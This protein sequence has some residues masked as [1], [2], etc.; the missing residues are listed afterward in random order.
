VYGVLFARLFYILNPPPSVVVFYDTTWYFSHPFDLQA[1]PLAIW[2]GG[3]SFAGAVVGVTVAVLF[4]LHRNKVDFWNWADRVI[5][6]L[7]VGAALVPWG[8]I[9][10][11]H[12]YGLPTTLPWGML[13]EHPAAPFESYTL[14]HPVP[15]Y[16][17]LLAFA[18]LVTT[19]L[20]RKR[21]PDI[22]GAGGQFLIVVIV[23]FSGI[24]ALEF[25]RADN[26]AVVFNLTDIQLVS[27]IYVVIALIFTIRGVRKI[28]LDRS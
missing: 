12:Q 15:A 7:L 2:S 22:V 17:S 16:V 1:G 11:Q 25:L 5:N 28:A 13:V 4:V 9:V 26:N 8:N 24:F 23:Y 27:V 14:F 3:L 21:I 6:G 19:V 10:N 18:I 20:L